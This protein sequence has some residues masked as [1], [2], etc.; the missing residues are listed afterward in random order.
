MTW[1]CSRQ[2][3]KKDCNQINFYGWFANHASIGCSHSVM[4][5]VKWGYTRRYINCVLVYDYEYL[6]GDKRI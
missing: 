1:L 4:L 2:K 5:Y 6:K 3:Q